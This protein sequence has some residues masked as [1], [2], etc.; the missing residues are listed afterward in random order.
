MSEYA[1]TIERGIWVLDNDD[2]CSDAQ[3]ALDALLA[4]NERLR[5]A[6]QEACDW[7]ES[8]WDRADDPDERELLSVDLRLKELRSL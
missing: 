1:K 4:E 6:L 2:V 7:A 5:D 3:M 8:A